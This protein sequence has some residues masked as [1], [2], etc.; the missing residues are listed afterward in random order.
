MREIESG[1]F[2]EETNDTAS[3]IEQVEKA[4]RILGDLCAR[5]GTESS[6]WAFAAQRSV[7][8][9]KSRGEI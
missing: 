3:T 8:S 1:S 4:L 9:N 5:G 6:G 2:K 7:E